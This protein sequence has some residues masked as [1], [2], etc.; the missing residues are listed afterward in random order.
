[1]RHL[2]A[3]VE[4]LQARLQISRALARAKDNDFDKAEDYLRDAVSFFKDARQKLMDDTAYDAKLDATAD[5]L[6]QAVVAV[7]ARAADMRSCIEKV[8]NESDTLVS[9]LESDEQAAQNGGN[10]DA[11]TK[12]PLAARTRVAAEASS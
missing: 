7:K 10:S 4:T 6:R 1:V 11:G 3:R 2:E 5:A 8:L 9:A 12:A